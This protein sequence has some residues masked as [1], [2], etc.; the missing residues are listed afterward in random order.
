LLFDLTTLPLGLENKSVTSQITDIASRRALCVQLT[1]DITRNGKPDVDYVDMP[2]FAVLPFN[3]ATGVLSVDIYSRLNALAPPYARAFAGLAYHIADDFSAFEAVYLRP[4]NGASLNPPPPRD[5][6]AVQ[7]FAYPD[8]RY[9]RLRDTYPDG[10]Y[11]AAADIA[12][13]RWTN[14][15]IE[16]EATELKAFVDGQN[17]LSL[18]ELKANAVTGA[19]GLFVDIGTEAFFSN[20]HVESH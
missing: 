17:V 6:R 13:E 10:R 16:I 4:L 8:W 7:Y 18:N 2:T 12:P 3:F 15:R 9:E 14:L 1:E 19:V 20:L 5:K 11:E